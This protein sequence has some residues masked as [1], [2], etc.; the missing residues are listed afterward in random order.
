MGE[1]QVPQFTS[2][3][4][5]YKQLFGSNLSNIVD[6]VGEKRFN[7]ILSLILSSDF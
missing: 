6:K 7:S 5:L 4:G 2:I 3:K 1:N